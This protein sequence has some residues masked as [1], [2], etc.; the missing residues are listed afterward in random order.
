MA[1][2]TIRETARI[3][4]YSLLRYLLFQL[5]PEVAHRLALASLALFYRC[6]LTRL[7]SRLPTQPRNIMGLTFPNPIG[8]AAG[9]DKNGDYI[10]A[11]ASLG[12][13]FIEIGTVTPNPS[14]G[15]PK[16]RLFRLPEY[17]AL[18]NR[19]G[20]NNK[21][22]EHVITQLKKRRFQGILGVNIGKDRNTPV[23][24]AIDDYLLGFRSVAPYADYVTLNISSPNSPGLRDLQQQTW[25][26]QLLT[27]LKQAQHLFHQIQ[28]RYV[29][30]FIKIAPDLTSQ[31]LQEMCQAMLTHQIDGV[32]A[33][34][35]TL[36]R[37][38][39]T[40]PHSKEIGGLSGQPLSKRT[41]SIIRE[42]RHLLGNDILIIASGGIMSVEDAKQ[43][44]AAGA[45]LIQVYTGMIYRGPQLIRE[46]V[47]ATTKEIISQ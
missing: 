7:L 35:T 26:T 25:L 39:M 6:Q 31:Q 11:L 18:I 38:N 13:G 22:L 2:G 8:L 33:T 21:G 43:K 15:N 3:M 9:F 4:I 27:A 42:L 41:T 14:P 34:N 16:P 1:N 12:F 24:K 5:S 29:P 30:L 17:Q 44:Q 19:M 10:D 45:N 32:I 47:R 40:H 28:H 37:E 20:F 46:L 36:S 23:E